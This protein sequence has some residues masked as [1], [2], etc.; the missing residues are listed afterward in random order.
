MKGFK[1]DYTPCQADLDNRSRQLNDQDPL[2]WANRNESKPTQSKTRKKSV[3]H[4]SSK[5]NPNW[6]TKNGT[7]NRSGSGRGNNPVKK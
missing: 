5:K 3:T 7:S 4:Q 2:F 6:P 1:K